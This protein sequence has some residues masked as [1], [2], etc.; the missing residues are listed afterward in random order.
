MERKTNIWIIENIKP[1][2][3]L[4][5]RVPKAALTYFGHVVRAGGME[6]DVM[7]GIMNG[8]RRRGR[9]RQRWLD[10]LMGYSSGA[11]ISNMR[12]Y[13]RDRARY[14]R[15][16]DVLHNRKCSPC[17]VDPCLDLSLCVSIF[18]HFGSQVCELCYVFYIL[19]SESDWVGCLTVV[20]HCFGFVFVDM[21][22]NFRCV[23]DQFLSFTLCGCVQAEICHLQSLG[24]LVILWMSI[25]SVLLI[26]QSIARQNRK[27][28]N[29]HP[30]FTPVLMSNSSVKCWPHITF[31]LNPS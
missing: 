9:P 30:C 4:E 18:C 10:T 28:D 29:I 26:I 7:L 24:L 22:S 2:W 8:A 20:S 27:G 12:R 31:D 6:D 1:E 16:P 5:S 3:T 11:S 21:T 13:A 15:L 14:F 19:F 23:S 25:W 17:L